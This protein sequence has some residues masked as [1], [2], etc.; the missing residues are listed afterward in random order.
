MQ[1]IGFIGVGTMGKGMVENLAKNGFSVLAYN[2]TKSR[3]ESLASDKITIVDN[4]QGVHVFQAMNHCKKYLK[5]F[6]HILQVRH[7]LIVG[8]PQLN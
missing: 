2:R 4:P 3:I 1:T 8:R 7:L 6:K 5:Q